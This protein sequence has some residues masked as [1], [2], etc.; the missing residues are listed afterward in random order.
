M[1][2]KSLKIIMLASPWRN[3]KVNIL[4]IG[5]PVVQPL[6]RAIGS[7]S[8]IENACTIKCSDASSRYIC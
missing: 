3:E 4:L 6:W 2:F 1:L 8:K 5:M 7:I